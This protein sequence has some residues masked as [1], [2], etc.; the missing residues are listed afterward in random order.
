MLSNYVSATQQNRLAE[1]RLSFMRK[2][3]EALTLVP[4]CIQ[5]KIHIVR[6]SD[7]AYD[8]SCDENSPLRTSVGAVIGLG[9]R[10][11]NQVFGP[12]YR[13]PNRCDRHELWGS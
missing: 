11:T 9:I 7:G 10:S 3:N 1:W 5:I 2:G 13:W 6:R 12:V 8:Q 4:D